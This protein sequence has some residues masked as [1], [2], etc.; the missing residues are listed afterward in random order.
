MDPT[1]SINNLTSTDFQGMIRTNVQNEGYTP[2]P[3]WAGERRG[4]LG[5]EREREALPSPTAVTT[6]STLFQEHLGVS[7]HHRL[8]IRARVLSI[9]LT[10]NGGSHRM[11]SS[12]ERSR[13]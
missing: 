3:N 8:A 1:L 7:A 9:G 13:R 10:G 2:K 4:Y 5:R 12:D 11:T 6:T